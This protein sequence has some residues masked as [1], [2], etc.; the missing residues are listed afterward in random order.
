MKEGRAAQEAQVKCEAGNHIRGSEWIGTGQQTD[1]A[2]EF[3]VS[4]G[5]K[6]G[7]QVP[8]KR[9]DLNLKH[10]K[11]ERWKWG[12]GRPILGGR[13]WG[14]AKAKLWLQTCPGCLEGAWKAGD[15]IG[16]MQTSLPS[17]VCWAF[18]E[19]PWD[20]TVV[21]PECQHRD[22]SFIPR[23]LENEWRLFSLEVVRKSKLINQKTRNPLGM[24]YGIWGIMGFLLGMVWE[25]ERGTWCK[26]ILWDVPWVFDHQ[27]NNREGKG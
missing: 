11:M 22:L 25:W 5:T 17:E 13:G 2:T 15:N 6:T 8:Y 12:S 10:R 3:W 24:Y 20:K 27:R 4:L 18:C 21:S 14:I 19:A 23:A 7:S 9:W 26:D 16:L 1:R